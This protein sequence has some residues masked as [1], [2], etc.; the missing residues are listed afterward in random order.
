MEVIWI[1]VLLR[2]ELLVHELALI[3]E[4]LSEYAQLSWN[5]IVVVVWRGNEG[6]TI[7]RERGIILI[8]KG[9]WRHFKAWHLERWLLVHHVRLVQYLRS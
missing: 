2:K 4:K 7:G 1:H 6:L 8:L 5:G 3:L 9:I